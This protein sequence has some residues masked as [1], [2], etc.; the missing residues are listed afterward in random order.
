V[1]RVERIVV[2]TRPRAESGDERRM[3]AV[4]DDG[5]RIPPRLP[6]ASFSGTFSFGSPPTREEMEEILRESYRRRGPAT[7]KGLS[8]A[9]ADEGIAA[10]EDELAAL[11]L[12]FEY[13]DEPAEPD[14]ALEAHRAELERKG[15]KWR[16]LAI[17][18]SI[19]IGA[20]WPSWHRYRRW[21]RQTWRRRIIGGIAGWAFLNLM[22]EYARAGRR[23]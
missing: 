1:A 5:R 17:A 13:S 9:L 22:R 14:P 2:V 18:L 15:R 3:Y 23:A 6:A 20:I 11:P 12:G 19:V 8:I 21:E 10:T 7:F 16:W 4:L